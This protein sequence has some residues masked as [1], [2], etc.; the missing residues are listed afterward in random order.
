MLPPSTLSQLMALVPSGRMPQPM[1]FRLSVAGADGIGK[2]VGVLEFS[3]PDGAVVVPLW[4]MRSLGVRWIALDPRPPP[5][6][7]L[8]LTSSP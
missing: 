5:A 6:H 1:L 7:A 4:V 8:T 2:H 3:A